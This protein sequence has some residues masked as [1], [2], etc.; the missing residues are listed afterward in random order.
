MINLE[1]SKTMHMFSAL[2]NIYNAMT[3][4][5]PGFQ[6]IISYSLFLLIY[7]VDTYLHAKSSRKL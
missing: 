6:P 4:D 7:D 3:H 5:V 1:E 2:Y